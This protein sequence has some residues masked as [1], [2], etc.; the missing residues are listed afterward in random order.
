MPHYF[1]LPATGFL[2]DLLKN[3]FDSSG[4]RRNIAVTLFPYC[5]NFQITS[6]GTT[7]IFNLLFTS[8]KAQVGYKILIKLRMH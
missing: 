8:I 6:V 1:Q 5:C 2:V 4:E 3:I 7:T